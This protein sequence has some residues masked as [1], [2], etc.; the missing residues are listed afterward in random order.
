MKISDAL[1]IDLEQHNAQYPVIEIEITKNVH[2]RFIIIDES[3]Y[4]IGASIKDLGKKIFA[5]S[6]LSVNHKVLLS[7][8]SE[9]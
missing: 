8:I 6:L 1:K 4:H 2:D 3:V 5:F 9:Q 7:H